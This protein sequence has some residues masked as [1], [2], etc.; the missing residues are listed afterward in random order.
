MKNSP[1]YG[2]LFLSVKNISML[3]AIEVVAC[4]DTKLKLLLFFKIRIISPLLNGTFLEHRY[5]A[6]PC[7][8]HCHKNW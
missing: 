8:K 3:T 5:T 6:N 2:K 7:E 1:V 4:P